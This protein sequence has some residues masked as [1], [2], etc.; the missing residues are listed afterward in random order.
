MQYPSYEQSKT[1]ARLLDER[2]SSITVG[3]KNNKKSSGVIAVCLNLITVFSIFP[4]LSS[5]QLH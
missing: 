2:P 1:Y 3:L 5:L 4:I